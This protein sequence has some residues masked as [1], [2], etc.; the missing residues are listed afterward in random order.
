MDLIN[1]DLMTIEINKNNSHMKIYKCTN[2]LRQEIRQF[3]INVVDLNI[4]HFWFNGYDTVNLVKN[5]NCNLNCPK[6]K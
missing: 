5:M 6:K 2:D 3:N 1:C 4:Y